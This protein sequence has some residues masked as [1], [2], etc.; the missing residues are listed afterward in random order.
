MFT[1]SEKRQ[2]NKLNQTLTREIKIGLAV[3]GQP[4]ARVFRDF[5]DHLVQLVPNIKVTS[6]DGS[7]KQPPEIQIGDGLR[8]QAIPSGLEMQPFTEA[9][10]ALDSKSSSISESI[11]MKLQRNELPATL[12]AFISPHCTF[13]PQVIRQLIPLSMAG[14]GVQLIIVDGALFPDLAQRHQIQSVPTILLDEQFRWRGAVPME[15]MVD[16][17]TD[18]ALWVETGERPG[19]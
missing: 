2:L 11:K 14:A 10:A 4:Q 5:C 1:E 9:L 19:S 13:C 6:E 3:A 17:L 15:E 18:L 8:Y 7:P 16:A 12:T